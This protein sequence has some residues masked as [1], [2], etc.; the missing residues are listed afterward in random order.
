MKLIVKDDYEEMTMASLEI[1]SQEFFKANVFGFA[2]GKTQ[3][4]LYEKLSFLCLSGK[5]SFADKISFNLDEYYGINHADKESLNNFMEEHLFKNIDLAKKNMYFPE[6]DVP[7]RFSIERYQAALNTY[8]PI[9]LLILGIGKNGHI[10]FNEPGSDPR[11][12]VHLVKLE[13]ETIRRNKAPSSL[14][15]TIGIRDILE[16]KTILLMASGKDKS[17]ALH[18]ALKEEPHTSVP[19]SFLQLHNNLFVVADSDAAALL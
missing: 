17:N 1:F 6:S 4:L 16:S 10:A 13:A 7:E 5:I 14:A 19:A 11:M 2:A 15:I 8:G 18:K 3:D 9:D 12:G